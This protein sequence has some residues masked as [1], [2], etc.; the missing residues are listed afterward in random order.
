MHFSHFNS[1]FLSDHWDVLKTLF[2]FTFFVCVKQRKQKQKPAATM[3]DYF[4]CKGN[5]LPSDSFC[6]LQE[7]WGIR[8]I[9]LM[10]HLTGANISGVTD[11]IGKCWQQ[12]PCQTPA[13]SKAKTSISKVASSGCF[14]MTKTS[15]LKMHKALTHRDT[16]TWEA[17]EE[18]QAK[19]CSNLRSTTCHSPF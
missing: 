13:A 9:S 5:I 16:H 8:V 19:R 14:D 7:T 15:T 4:G 18:N 11:A 3:L 17:R 6:K 1:T 2:F 12:K 10:L